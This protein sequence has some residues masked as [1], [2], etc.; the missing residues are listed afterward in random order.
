MNKNDPILAE[1]DDLRNQ[2]K[3]LQEHI[4]QLKDLFMGLQADLNEEKKLTKEMRRTFIQTI[5]EVIRWHEHRSNGD[6]LWARIPEH[7]KQQD[8]LARAQAEAQKAAQSSS[9]PAPIKP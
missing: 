5:Q 3:K 2:N 8:Q 4:D 7:I 9:E 1:I 6:V